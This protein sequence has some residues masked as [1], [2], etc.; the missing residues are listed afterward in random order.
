[1]SFWLQL[2]I[3]AAFLIAFLAYH[4]FRAPYDIYLEQHKTHKMEIAEKDDSIKATEA[5]IESLNNEILQFKEQTKPLEI[6][7]LSAAVASPAN[8]THRVLAAKN[9]LTDC[10]IEIHNPNPTQAIDG[11][12][13]RLLRIEPPMENAK[14]ARHQNFVNRLVNGP[15]AKRQSKSSDST[16][17]CDLRNMK[18]SLL[19]NEL[20]GDQHRR[21][22]FFT[23][24]RRG[25][26][27]SI[28]FDCQPTDGMACEFVALGEHVFTVEVS[29][30]GLHTKLIQFGLKF[31]SNPEQIPDG[32]NPDSTKSK[33]PVFIIRKISQFTPKEAEIAE[34]ESQIQSLNEKLAEQ[35]E[36]DKVVVA[37]QVAKELLGYKLFELQN[38]LDEAF[39]INRLGFEGELKKKEWEFTN[40]HFQNTE[41]VMWKQLLIAEAARFRAVEPAQVKPVQGFNAEQIMDWQWHINCIQAKR[42]KLE[43]ILKE[44]GK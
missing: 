37:K 12:E 36:A 20:K 40:A 23:A 33:E 41:A 13:I 30:R 26:D 27:I 5:V 11:I 31:F 29:A 2:G 28:K 39:Q 32:I 18:F 1:M 8:D 15:H 17:Q 38:R 4:I 9:N 42:D 43:E 21:M 14:T 34:L 19:D 35:S 6:E 25:E 16:E 44:I 3:P 24:E 7:A 10:S 22:H